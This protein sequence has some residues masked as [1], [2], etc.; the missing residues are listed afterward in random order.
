MRANRRSRVV[1]KVVALLEERRAAENTAGWAAYLETAAAL[2]TGAA[3]VDCNKGGKSADTR[4][5]QS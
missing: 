2:G 4:F 3:K 5:G 1:A